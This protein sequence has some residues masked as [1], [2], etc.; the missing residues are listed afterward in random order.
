[1]CSGFMSSF[2]TPDGARYTRSSLR[3]LAPPPVPVTQPRCQNFAQSSGIRFAGC[4]ESCEII[5]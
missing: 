1:M 5:R 2:W 3:I 4:W